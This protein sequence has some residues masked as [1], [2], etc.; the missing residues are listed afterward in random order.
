MKIRHHLMLA[1]M[2]VLTALVGL[3]CYWSFDGI[4]WNKIL[5]KDEIVFTTTKSVYLS[6]DT[7]QATFSVCKNRLILP[8]IQWSLV[9]TYLRIYPS[10]RANKNA[11]G[12]R[13]EMLTTI[14]KLPK[15][16]PAETYHFSGTLVYN[17]NPIRQI[18]VPIITNEFEVQ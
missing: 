9:D 4:L 6:G 2:L 1:M 3:F 15:G 14:E 16:L 12:C 7:V 17:L 8:V 5:D 18:I 11:L 13:Q 10:R